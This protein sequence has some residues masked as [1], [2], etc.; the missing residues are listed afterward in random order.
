MTA[1]RK[2][3]SPDCAPDEFHRH[4]SEGT[5]FPWCWANALYLEWFSER[6][7]RV[8]IETTAFQL[9]IDPEPAWT[10]T[11]E[12][13]SAQQIQNARAMLGFMDRLTES[14]PDTAGAGAAYDAD[15]P[16]S[17]IEAA[18]DREDARMSLLLDRVQARIERD[19]FEQIDFDTL[20][21][22]EKERLR[23]ERG[24]PPPEPLTREEEAERASEIED[25]VEAQRES[26][27]TADA[28]H[29]KDEGER[30]PLIERCMELALELRRTVKD[31][32]WLSDHDHPEHPLRELLNGVMIA[33]PILA[34]A[35]PDSLSEDEWPPDPL[36]AGNVLV[37]LKKARRHLENALLGIDCA[38]STARNPNAWRRQNS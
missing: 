34:G 28:D 15:A 12:E 13:E 7:G 30:H 37:R 23:R 25:L 3:K 26:L 29:W 2:V 36:F 6:N 35:L 22:E 19:G 5:P 10:L 11:P 17:A 31:A 9:T 14:L 24:E 1:S 20:Y 16:Q 27:E 8:V 4:L 21:D 33:G 18:A 32:G 38:E